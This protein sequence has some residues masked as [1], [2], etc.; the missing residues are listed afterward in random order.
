MEK[1]F[2]TKKQINHLTMTWAALM[3]AFLESVIF[4]KET[5]G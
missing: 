1:Y 5:T 2:Q 3:M 4:H